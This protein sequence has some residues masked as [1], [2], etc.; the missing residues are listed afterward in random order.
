MRAELL[1]AVREFAAAETEYERTKELVITAEDKLAHL[2]RT[3]QLATIQWRDSLA[4]RDAAAHRLNV[5]RASLESLDVM[6]D[7]S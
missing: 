3:V 2:A 7:G 1:D 5:A 4:R 6:E